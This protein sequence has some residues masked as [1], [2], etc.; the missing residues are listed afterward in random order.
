MLVCWMH[1]QEALVKQSA[2]SDAQLAA[3]VSKLQNV[4]VGGLCR[5]SDGFGL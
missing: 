4:Q 2:A 5:Q 3:V 1:M